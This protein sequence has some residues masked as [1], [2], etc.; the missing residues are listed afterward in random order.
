MRDRSNANLTNQSKDELDEEDC[1]FRQFMSSGCSSWFNHIKDQTFSSTFCKL[2]PSEAQVIVKHWDDLRKLKHALA[3]ED[4]NADEVAL[5]VQELLNTALQKL[6]ELLSRLSI[7]IESETAKS[8]V[9]L[10]FVKLST[11]SPKD[12]KKALAAAR[13]AYNKRLLSASSTAATAATSPLSDNDK[14]RILCETTT[15]S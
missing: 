13:I 2:F 3:R 6:E 15:Q 10:A 14:W 4:S 5:C 11:R 9:K 12:S 7:A 1:I 8:P